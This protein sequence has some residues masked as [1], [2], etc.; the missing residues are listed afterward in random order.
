MPPRVLYCQPRLADPPRTAD[1]LRLNDGRRSVQS[2]LL[3]ESHQVVFAAFQKVAQWR[4]REIIW[5]TRRAHEPG[6]QLA[7]V[8]QMLLPAR[9]RRGIQWLV[10]VPH[11]LVPGHALGAGKGVLTIVF[12]AQW[13]PK[14][15]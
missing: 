10:R 8:E 4:E 1:R 14:N 15:G 7:Q 5:W 3:V 9:F 12:P 13:S 11:R 2:E 6:D